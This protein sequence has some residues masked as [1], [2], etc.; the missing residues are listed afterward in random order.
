MKF[1]RKILFS[2]S[3]LTLMLGISV[4]AKAMGTITNFVQTGGSQYTIDL[5]WDSY[6]G[7]RSYIVKYYN[8]VIGVETKIVD[9]NSVT[10]DLK[11]A[12]QSL[13]CFVSAY[14]HTGS[15]IATC[16]SINVSSVPGEMTGWKAYSW[17]IDGTKGMIRWKKQ[18]YKCLEGYQ[19][20][21]L[22]GNKKVASGTS[23]K[24]GFKA[25]APSSTIY[26]FKVRGY[27]LSNNKKKLYGPWHTETIVPQPALISGTWNSTRDSVTL[28]WRK[29][30]GA[31]KYIVYGST[32]KKKGYKK[33]ATLSK[34]KSSYTV[35]KV[36][37]KK[38]VKDKNYYL[39]VVAYYKKGSTKITSAHTVFWYG[40]A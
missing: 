12:D 23:K 19:W 31:T 20:Q 25:K 17:S 11:N 26:T 34:K 8:D 7:A 24:L 39:Y 13:Q 35:K 27:V 6:S 22:K 14:D 3:I 10:L 36:K 18:Q 21:L 15:Q 37:G 38:L 16:K 5:S 29:V 28:K 1:I 32:K 9:K 33:I 30:K 40:K 2:V 4:P